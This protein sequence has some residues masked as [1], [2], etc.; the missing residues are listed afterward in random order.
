MNLSALKVFPKS[1]LFIR[2]SKFHRFKYLKLSCT[3]SIDKVFP[4][5]V[6]F[7][8]LSKFA[9]PHRESNIKKVITINKELA[10]P[11]KCTLGDN[12]L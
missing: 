6:L 1:V 3:F 7:T 8:K 9:S 5:S 11:F 12:L 10:E 4:K 2:I